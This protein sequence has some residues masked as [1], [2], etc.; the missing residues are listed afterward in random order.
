LLTGKTITGEISKTI[1]EM[2]ELVESS[3]FDRRELLNK[4][5]YIQDLVD[6]YITGLDYGSLTDM[7]F[8]AIKA[9]IDSYVEQVKQ[10]KEDILNANVAGLRQALLDLE[11]KIRS[12]FRSLSLLRG[13]GSEISAIR[14]LEESGYSLGIDELGEI[15]S[16]IKRLSPQAKRVIKALIDS[17]LKAVPLGE[18]AKRLGYID[19]E[20]RIS[21]DFQKVIE[22]ILSAIPSLVSLDPTE[23]GRGYVLK[24]RGW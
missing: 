12:L 16:K 3:L 24:W 7:K 22:E 4:L 9:E 1:S 5:D 15:D 11:S 20:G 10:V 23:G 19:E 6:S 8:K 17:P 13:E 2:L 14:L 18:L 21:S